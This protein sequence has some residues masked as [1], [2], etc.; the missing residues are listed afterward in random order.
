MRDHQMR[1]EAVGLMSVVFWGA[2]T[3]LLSRFPPPLTLF[4]TIS[5]VIPL[6]I[7]CLFVGSGLLL[8]SMAVTVVVLRTLAA[9]LDA[10]LGI[11]HGSRE[12]DCAR[13]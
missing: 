12:R 3:W 7:G 11:T 10:L 6:S 4:E 9:F 8:G 13:C 2:G 5:C 1:L